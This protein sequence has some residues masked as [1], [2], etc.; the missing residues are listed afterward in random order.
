MS[1]HSYL[2]ILGLLRLFKHLTYLCSA[3]ISILYPALWYLAAIMMDVLLLK[4]VVPW[5]L[6]LSSRVFWHRTPGTKTWFHCLSFTFEICI[7]RQQFGHMKLMSLF[8]TPEV[9]NVT[10]KSP[11]PQCPA[12]NSSHGWSSSTRRCSCAYDSSQD[13][14]RHLSSP[15]RS[16]CADLCCEGICSSRE[17]CGHIAPHLFSYAPQST[18]AQTFIK[19][20]AARKH[21]AAPLCFQ[22]VRPCH[23]FRIYL[24]SSHFVFWGL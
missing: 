11:F 4:I 24:Q 3:G 9:W 6:Q 13:L 19:Y 2:R 5:S 10:Q 14:P 16:P 7:L 22:E 18:M 20:S 15:G 17:K 21:L 1:L 12:S 8:G 23:P